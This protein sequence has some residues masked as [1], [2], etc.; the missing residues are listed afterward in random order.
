MTHNLTDERIVVF[1]HQARLIEHSEFFIYDDAQR[2]LGTVASVSARRLQRLSG[3]NREIRDATGDPVLLL[4]TKVVG[5]RRRTQLDR[6][7]GVHIGE[8]VQKSGSTLRIGL[9]AHDSQ[10]GEIVATGR[11]SWNFAIRD[12]STTQVGSIIYRPD[13]DSGMVRKYMIRVELERP[14]ADPLASLILAA[15][16]DVYRLTARRDAPT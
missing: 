11:R 4:T 1:V 13:S 2:P 10:E 3:K 5:F 9:F 6:P 16:P 12:R 15:V 14:L 7:D 8:V